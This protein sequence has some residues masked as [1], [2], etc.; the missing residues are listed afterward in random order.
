MS[1]AS[2]ISI[3]TRRLDWPEYQTFDIDAGQTTLADLRR[4]HPAVLPSSHQLYA[5]TEDGR[6]R[7]VPATEVLQAHLSY[8]LQAELI[9]SEYLQLQGADAL[10]C[11]SCW[12]QSESLDDLRYHPGKLT[13]QAWHYTIHTWEWLCCSRIVSYSKVASRVTTDGCQVGLC[14][15]CRDLSAY[16][17]AVARYEAELEKL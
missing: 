17:A 4:G 3:N 11:T 5:R 12:A 7:R 16:D 15:A 6:W 9:E 2:Q 10:R 8:H 14:A 13:P 1:S